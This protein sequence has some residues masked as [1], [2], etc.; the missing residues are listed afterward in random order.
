MFSHS[1]ADLHL[2]CFL[3]GAVMVSAVMS[4]FIHVF[5]VEIQIFLVDMYFEIELEGDKRCAYL[6]FVVGVVQSLNSV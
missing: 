6:A 5:C 1:T 4:I 3:F 2:D